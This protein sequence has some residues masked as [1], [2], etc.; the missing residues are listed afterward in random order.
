MVNGID[1]RMLGP[2]RAATLQASVLVF[3]I[4][5]CYEAPA[6]VYLQ[7][8]EKQGHHGWR[9]PGVRSKQGFLTERRAPSACVQVGGILF[10]GAC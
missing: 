1:T 6:A 7:S 2:P 8:M 9:I 3:K 5:P 10:R 4:L